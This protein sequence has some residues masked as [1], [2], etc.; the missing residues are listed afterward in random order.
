MKLYHFENI[1]T[2][3]DPINLAILLLRNLEW[4]YFRMFLKGL[5]SG[6]LSLICKITLL[7]HTTVRWWPSHAHLVFF[8]FLW[9]FICLHGF[10][11]SLFILPRSCLVG[12]LFL[13][14]HLTPFRTN[15]LRQLSYA[16]ARIIC[17]EL[18]DSR[19]TKIKI[20]IRNDFHTKWTHLRSD[21]VWKDHK[22]RRRT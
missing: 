10:F 8:S 16:D 3:G 20:D 11:V 7:F 9:C 4:T 22:W 1:S 2:I 17:L 18:M 12:F 6:T 21:I 14:G 19:K 15:E 5:F 13:R